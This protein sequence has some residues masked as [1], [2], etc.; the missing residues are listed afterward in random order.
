MARV[1]NATINTSRVL[2]RQPGKDP[3]FERKKAD[4]AREQVAPPTQVNKTPETVQTQKGQ[5]INKNI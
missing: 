4:Q 3:S 1:E 2:D 5:N